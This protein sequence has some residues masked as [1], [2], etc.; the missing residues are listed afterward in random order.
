VENLM[1]GGELAY[2]KIRRAN[3]FD[4]SDLDDYVTRNRRKQRRPGR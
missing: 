2:V 1:S 3:R 4:P